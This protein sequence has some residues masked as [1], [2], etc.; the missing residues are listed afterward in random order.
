MRKDIK[1][2]II[3]V[4]GAVSSLAVIFFFFTLWLFS[5]NSIDQPLKEAWSSSISFLSVLSTLAAAYI[6]AFLFSDWRDPES[7]KNKRE[8]ADRIWNDLDKLKKY[9][10]SFY[11]FFS[12]AEAAYLKDEY[13]NFDNFKSSMRPYFYDVSDLLLQ[14]NRSILRLRALDS[15]FTRNTAVQN[16][17]TIV[18]DYL[19]IFEI[20][21]FNEFTYKRFVE[22]ENNQLIKFN[23]TEEDFVDALKVFFDLR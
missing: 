6:A 16:I 4:F 13:R 23:S 2:K 22:R 11:D 8:L 21:K 3:D 9:L 20:N 15:D 10:V 7:F 5:Y 14:L 17:S 18:M 12:E 19:D 1:V